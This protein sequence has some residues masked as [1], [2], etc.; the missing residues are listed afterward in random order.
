MKPI[1]WNVS[2]LRGAWCGKSFAEAF[3]LASRMGRSRGIVRV[4]SARMCQKGRVLCKWRRMSWKPGM[5]V[6]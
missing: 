3:P 5:L 2:G 1:G 4:S 6:P